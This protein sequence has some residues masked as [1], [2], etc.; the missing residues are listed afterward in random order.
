MVILG[1]KPSSLFFLLSPP[2][3]RLGVQHCHP[4][5]VKRKV[6]Q[7][8]NTNCA[9]SIYVHVICT[10]CVS[11]A[12]D[13]VDLIHS[14]WAKLSQRRKKKEE[15]KR[16]TQIKT[17]TDWA[18]SYNVAVRRHQQDG[19]LESNAINPEQPT[20]PLII[21]S[22]N[23]ENHMMLCGNRRVMWKPWGGP[24]G[25]SGRKVQSSWLCCF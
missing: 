23:C 22:L 25:W 21:Q 4:S 8:T 9:T 5:H 17:F 13:R 3:K 19:W 24:A 20:R 18:D 15:I 14:S 10:C 11:R 12:A 2:H 1:G 7:R 16:C 6:A